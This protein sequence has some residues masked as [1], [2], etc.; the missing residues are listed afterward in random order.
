MPDEWWARVKA[1]EVIGSLKISRPS[2]ISIENIAWTQGALVIEDGLR[3]CDARLVHTPGIKPAILRVRKP[4]SPPGKRR[5]AIAHQLGHLKLAHS[6]GKPTECADKEFHAWYRDQRDQEVEANVFAA[7][8]L[9][10]EPLIFPRL[11]NSVPSFELIEEISS[12]FQTTL[13]AT[14]IRYVQLSGNRCA[15]VCSTAG[16]VRWSWPS[17]EFHHWIKRGTKLKAST[18]A[19]DYFERGVATEHMQEVQE[20]TRDSWIA[21]ESMQDT[22]KEQSRVLFSYDSVLTLVWIDY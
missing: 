11:Q 21:G 14:A 19:I 8:L 1:R 7:E 22:I 13:T 6:P 5:F 15:I 12:D 17:P 9:M 20:V 2:D 16:E 3:G 18:Y 10:P 4:L